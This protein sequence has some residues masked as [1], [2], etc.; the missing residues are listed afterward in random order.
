MPRSGAAIEQVPLSWTPSADKRVIAY[1]IYRGRYPGY[2]WE[3][4]GGVTAQ[5]TQY[6]DDTAPPPGGS[7]RLRYAVSAVDLQGNE[8]GLARLPKDVIVYSSDE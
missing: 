1:F 2:E 5:R 8:S 4:V 7:L 6:T 3:R